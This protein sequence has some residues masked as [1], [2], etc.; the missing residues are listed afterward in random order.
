MI[1]AMAV[2]PFID[3]PAK[4]LGQQGMP[5]L[6]IVWARAMFG[7]LMSLPFA[8]R[9]QGLWAFCPAW[10]FH[11]LARAILLFAATRLFFQS[12]KHLAI[13]EALAIFFVNP[14]V[15]VV[16]SALLL[17]ETVGMRRWIAVAV[18]FAGTMIIIRPGLVDLNP[19]TLL[20]LPQGYRSGPIS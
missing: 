15:V 18:G 20:P 10:P 17:R 13:A 6:M 8:V 12:L 2:L 4:F 7:A 1:L 3:V 19:S 14:L 5:I 16:L 11:H 9:A